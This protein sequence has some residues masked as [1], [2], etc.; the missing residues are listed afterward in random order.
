MQSIKIIA[1][2][3]EKSF[4]V[5]LAALC[6]NRELTKRALSASYLTKLLTPC[7][8]ACCVF[9]QSKPLKY[10]CIS[11][12][13]C[14]IGLLIRIDYKA[15]V[16]PVSVYAPASL[17]CLFLVSCSVQGGFC[18]NVALLIFDVIINMNFMCFV[19]VFS[20]EESSAAYNFSLPEQFWVQFSERQIKRNLQLIDRPKQYCAWQRSHA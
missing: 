14:C 1:C 10:C 9:K 12:W 15:C 16:W 3:K 11:D 17:M 13:V 2:Q 20:Q 4:N 18:W 7:R 6:L 19:S 8:H 5:K